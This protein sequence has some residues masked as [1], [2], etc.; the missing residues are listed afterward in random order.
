MAFLVEP[1]Q[2][3]AGIILPP[4]GYLAAAAA[5]CRAANVLFVADEIQS[6]LGRTG[7][8]LAVDHESVR[9]DLV[10]LGKALGAASSRCPPWRAAMT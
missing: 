5:A 2:G 1:I 9:P 6:G 7:T 8:T 10:L 4:D 3:E